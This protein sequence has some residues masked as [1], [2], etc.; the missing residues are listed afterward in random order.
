MFCARPPHAPLRFCHHWLFLLFLCVCRHGALSA[1]CHTAPDRLLNVANPILVFVDCSSFLSCAAA[2]DQLHLMVPLR[3]QPI[4][5]LRPPPLVESPV[6]RVSVAVSLALMFR[7]VAGAVASVAFGIVFASCCE[8]VLMAQRLVTLAF[9]F[10]STSTPSPIGPAPHHHV[11]HGCLLT[12]AVAV[13][14]CCCASA[15]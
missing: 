2:C 13:L 15:A 14:E 10:H 11:Y 9:S 5:G 4:R 3:Y 8:R 12:T 1:L 6:A 7:V